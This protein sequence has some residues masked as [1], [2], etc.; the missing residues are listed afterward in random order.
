MKSLL[1]IFRVR[2][3]ER[4]LAL[5]TVLVFLLLNAMVV[6]KYVGGFTRFH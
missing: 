1:S 2:R 6:Y 5:C 4:W 3:E